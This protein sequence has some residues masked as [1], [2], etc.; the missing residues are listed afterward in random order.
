M[1]CF[2]GMCVIFPSKASF[3]LT[4]EWKWTDIVQSVPL[5]MEPT[6]HGRPNDQIVLTCEIDSMHSTGRFGPVAW[7]ACVLVWSLA[8]L[9]VGLFAVCCCRSWPLLRALWMLSGLRKSRWSLFGSNKPF[10][11]A[12][13]KAI[14][15]L[16]YNP[17]YNICYNLY[18]NSF[19]TILQL[20]WL[21]NNKK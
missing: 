4:E 8:C 12:W 16:Y 10:A 15:Q 3:P 9:L 5:T 11:F 6:L 14:S 2:F 20:T 1:S 7:H 18:Y 21:L 17:Y 19:P 13:Y